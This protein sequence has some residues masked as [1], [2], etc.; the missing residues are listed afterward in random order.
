MIQELVPLYLRSEGLGLEAIG[1]ASLIGLPWSIKALWAPLVDRVGSLKGW[2]ILGLAICTLGSLMLPWVPVHSR[3]LMGI[4]L[5]IAVGSATQDIAIDGTL[6][7]ALPAEEVARANGLRVAA[8]RAAM[9]LTGGAAAILGDHLGWPLAFATMAGVQGLLMLAQG[10]CS[11]RGGAPQR[12]PLGDWF[13]ALGAWAAEPAAW[14]LFAMA[15]FFKL[16]D[17]AMAPMVK[18]FW[19][20]YGMSVTETAVF[21]TTFGAL[22]T[23]IGAIFGGDLMSR[24]GPRLGILLLGGAQA[25]SNLGYALAAR[26]GGVPAIYSASVVESFSAGMGTAALLGSFALAARGSQAATRFAILT[27]IVG[28]TRSLA[29]ALSG[30]AV[31]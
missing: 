14:G 25:L 10:L 29:G 5:G 7:T 26:G 24:L 2:M 16:G 6:A 1:L 21:S 4:L 30:S 20:D 17:A 19:L 8:Y 3:L 15:L 27:A 12:E 28:F 9:A 18:T 13:R 22:L 31:E 23:V 11:L